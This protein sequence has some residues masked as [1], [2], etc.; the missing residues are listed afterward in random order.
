[1]PLV[2][3]EDGCGWQAQGFFCTAREH[4]K[5]AHPGSPLHVFAPGTEQQEV[6]MREHTRARPRECRTRRRQVRFKLEAWGWESSRAVS[7]GCSTGREHHH[8]VGPQTTQVESECLRVAL[9][10]LILATC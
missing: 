3:T 5:S 4:A 1:M 8:L 7:G 10:E 2:C 9:P 6:E